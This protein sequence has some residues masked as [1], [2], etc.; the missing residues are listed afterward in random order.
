MYSSE[1]E[2]SCNGQKQATPDY[3]AC[4]V[5]ESWK[6]TQKK[7]IILNNKKS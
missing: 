7:K 5:K 3:G 2:L 4:G 1:P 6:G